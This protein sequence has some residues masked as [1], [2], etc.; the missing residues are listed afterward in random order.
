MKFSLV[1]KN[2]YINFDKIS[3]QKT[4]KR[5][6][7]KKRGPQQKATGLCIKP[8]KR[9]GGFV[10]NIEEINN[11]FEKLINNTT[12]FLPDGIV[13][14]NIKILQSLQI[15]SN[16]HPTPKKPQVL[17]AIEAQGKITLFN[18]EFIIWVAVQAES[19]PPCTLVFIARNSNDTIKP[20]LG[21]RTQGIYNRS[22]TIMQLID[23]FL[24]DIQETECV[25][26]QLESNPSEYSA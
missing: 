5:R 15:L 1:N 21:F 6:T 11:F 23:R 4:E 19:T 13:D 14:I 7:S 10:I 3:C 25:L 8:K 2:F 18:E 20:E 26:S 16:K 24:A 17:Q 9:Q 22:K 12:T